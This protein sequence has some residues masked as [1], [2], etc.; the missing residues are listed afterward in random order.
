MPKERKSVSGPWTLVADPPPC[1]PGN[2]SR[3]TEYCEKQRRSQ[4]CTCTFDLET[5]AGD[6]EELG[7]AE[8]AEAFEEELDPDALGDLAQ[9][10]LALIRARD[11]SAAARLQH[12]LLLLRRLADEGSGLR[13]AD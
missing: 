11:G 1:D 2:P 8:Q 3:A 9:R 4:R 6:M 5:I 12:E 10:L 13:P 7:L